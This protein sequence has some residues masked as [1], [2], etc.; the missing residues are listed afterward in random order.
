M[1][2]DAA[3]I[4]GLVVILRD[5]LDHMPLSSTTPDDDLRPGATLLVKRIKAGEMEGILIQTVANMQQKLRLAVNHV[6][7]RDV[8]NRAVKLIRA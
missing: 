2:N 7:C 8:V 4:Q 3:F 5:C 1:V 6:R